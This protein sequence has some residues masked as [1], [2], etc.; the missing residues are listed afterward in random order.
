MSLRTRLLLVFGGIVAITVALISFAVS[1][2]ARRSFERVDD[3][4]ATAVAGQFQREFE[5][6]GDALALRAAAIARS[7]PLRNM[8][9]ALSSPGGDPAPYVNLAAS[10]A[11]EQQL[12]FLEILSQD[13]TVIS[14]A[15]WP[16]R[17]GVHLPWVEDVPDW[18]RQHAFLQYEDV[19]DG[20]ELALVAV[21]EL[22]MADRRFL[23]VAGQRI[24]SNFLKS[25]V[26]PDG[27]RVLL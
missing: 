13:G 5:L 26:V 14:S 20:A 4:R 23:V 15:Q 1:L 8:A 18:S 22:T 7:Q 25:L 16:A 19:P 2:G 24:D 11:A 10:L 27:T 9:L 12:D 21:R 6:Q 17:F 3:Q